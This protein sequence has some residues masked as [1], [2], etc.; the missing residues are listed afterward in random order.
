[1]VITVFGLGF[2]GLTT[3]LGFSEYGHT[4][5]GVEVDPQRLHTIQS[6]YL[7]FLEEGLDEALR[8]HIGKRFHAI[9]PDALPDAIG[10]SQCVYFCVGTPYGHDGQADLTFLLGAIDQTL[11]LSHDG[12]FR[13]L[14][15]KSTIP[16][17]TTTTKIMPHIESRGFHVGKDIGVANNPEFL[18]EGHCWDDFMHADR[19]VLGVSDAR[20]EHVLR[21][22]Y[23]TAGT[24]VFCVTPGTGEFIKYLSNTL[25]ATLISYSNEMSV[26]AD[27]LG[28][29][30]TAQ[31][32]RILHMDKRW[33]GCDMA[34][35]VYPGCGYGGY[36]LPK[37]T[38]ALYAV[39][40]TAGFDAP[41]LRDVIAT[42]DRMPQV[43]A[44]RIAKVAG[45]DKGRTLA[46][47]G[48]S[49]KPGSDDVRDA[50][51]ARIVRQLLQMGYTRLIGYDPVAVE[52]FRRRYPDLAIT[53]TA[54]YDDALRQ[55]DVLIIATAWPEFADIRSRTTK[56][57]VDC[58]FM[59]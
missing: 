43:I 49:F 50:P 17:S 29:I 54:I 37:D 46:I 36:C 42:N 21:E 47:L 51:S 20:C 9:S 30:D 2:V 22:V 39:T 14:V 4:V 59:L 40:K 11:K 19:I 16:P 55:A 10:Q 6:G 18:R 44:S 3:A 28:D 32:F 8:R 58:R 41:I 26:I 33:G 45:P 31:A 23:A 12:Q 5:Y 48:L 35:Y 15:V 53:C 24:P 38:N 27:Q 52:E 1:M 56:P 34:S 13:V 57:V 7:P 25:L